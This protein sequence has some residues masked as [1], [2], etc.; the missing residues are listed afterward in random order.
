MAMNSHSVSDE[1]AQ[2]SNDHQLR[3]V[4]TRRDRPS[5]GDP[6]ASCHGGGGRHR[7]GRED[8][9]TPR[10]RRGENCFESVPLN[11]QR[12]RGKFHV[13]RGCWER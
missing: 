4:P 12:V 9:E 11:S 3:G 10:A 13:S 7:H 2:L 8:E 5:A 6:T 1:D